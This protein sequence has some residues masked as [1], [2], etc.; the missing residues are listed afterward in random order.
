MKP[1]RKILLPEAPPAVDSSSTGGLG[2]LKRVAKLPEELNLDKLPPNAQ[3]ASVD[4]RSQTTDS[5]KE[6]PPLLEKESAD[7]GPS[8]MPAQEHA[9]SDPSLT[10]GIAIFIALVVIV[11]IVQITKS[12]PVHQVEPST[13]DWG[14]STPSV[15]TAS[16]SIQNPSSSASTYQPNP[17]V[18]PPPSVSTP[19]PSPSSR[20]AA[21]SDLNPPAIQRSEPSPVNPNSYWGSH[22][23]QTSTLKYLKVIG[24][25]RGDTLSMRDRPDPNS[26]QVGQIPYNATRVESVDD[27]KNVA[28]YGKTPWYKVEW[29]GRVGWVNGT[30]LQFADQTENPKAKTEIGHSAVATNSQPTDTSEAIVMYVKVIQVEPGDRLTMR[31]APNPNSSPVGSIPHDATGVGLLTPIAAGVQYGGVKWF[32]VQWQGRM[33]WVNGTHLDRY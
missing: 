10:F 25:R 30:H 29:Q 19:L 4:S 2:L 27:L 21:A 18:A 20:S 9:G 26:R 14:N 12:S 17:Y 31:S 7:G 3:Q 11:I 6:V 15:T 33:G 8:S 23:P 5:R 22:A 32:K 13:I 1:D 16:S 24:V 28:Y